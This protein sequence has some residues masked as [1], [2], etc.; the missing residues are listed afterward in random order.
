M[1]LRHLLV[2][3]ARGAGVVRRG[4]QKATRTALLYPL[5]SLSL[6][7]VLLAINA[8]LLA[9]GASSHLAF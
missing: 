3:A 8:Y 2:A 6:Q 5:Q 7:L 9:R 1:G 4:L